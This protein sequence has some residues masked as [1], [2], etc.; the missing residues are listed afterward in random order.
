[1]RNYSI[2]G[3][4]RL[5]TSLGAALRRRGWH[6]GFIVDR[7]A[8]SAREA[9]RVIGAGTASTDLG[10]AA[11]AEGVLFITVPDDAVGSVARALARQPGKWSGRVVFHTSGF[12][13]SAALDAL[14]RKGAAT[15]ALHP[16]QSFPRR[17]RTALLFKGIYWDVEGPAEAIAAAR[18]VVSALGGHLI[19]LEAS[20]KPLYHAA[21]S[22]ASNAFVALEAAAVSLVEAA[23]LDRRRAQALL[24]PLVQGTLRNVKNLGWESV[25]TG[26]VSRGDIRTVE[27]HL[28]AL[29][30]RPLERAI[31]AALGAQALELARRRELQAA[32][33]RR[34]RALL[35]GR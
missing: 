31:Y 35:G 16:V 24:L 4:G 27:A 1:M 5:G 32:K 33:V 7:D 9:R 12:L 20:D 15:A 3:A 2:V 22:L 17:E 34:L 19:K 6:P 18:S 11:R 26:P 28:E 14:K 30:S 25:L 21:C 23:G 8:A 10:R 29:R 13:T